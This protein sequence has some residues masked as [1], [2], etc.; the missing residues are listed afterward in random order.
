VCG[1]LK[2][3]TIILEHM[4][5]LIYGQNYYLLLKHI[6]EHHEK[7]SIHTCRS[8]TMGSNAPEAWSP[9]WV[10]QHLR[11]MRNG[12]PPNDPNHDKKPLVGAERMLC[13]C[14]LKCQDHMSIDYDTYD[15]RYWSFPQPICLFHWGW[16]EEKP[17]KVVSVFTFTMH[18]LNNVI[19][20]HFLVFK[21]VHIELFPPPP[22]L[23]G[24]DFK[25]WIDDYMTPCDEEYVVWV[26]KNS[27]MKKGASNNK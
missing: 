6:K 22:K 7:R 11:E 21:G 19:S 16:N 25:K 3:A 13:K 23:P 17:Q 12:I 4:F 27:V 18:I 26:K 1:S 24:C 15:M 8:Q 9:R 5:L 14:D 10:R 2:K 20:N